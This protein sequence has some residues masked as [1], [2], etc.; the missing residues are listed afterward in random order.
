MLIDSGTVKAHP[1]L[2]VSGVWCIA[3][4]EYDFTED[5]DNS[6][7]ILASLKPIQLSHLNFDT[8]VEARQHFTTEIMEILC[9]TKN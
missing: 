5:K 1:K 6:P 9:K 3:D 7:W 8:Y 4:I 2:L